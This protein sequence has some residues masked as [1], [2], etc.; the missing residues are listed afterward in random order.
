MK[1]GLAVGGVLLAAPG[2]VSCGGENGD[3]GADDEQRPLRGLGRRLLRRG[4]DVREHLQRDGHGQPARGRGGAQGCGQELKYLGTPEDIPDGAREGLALTL[5]KLTALPDDADQADLL[6]VLDLNQRASGPSR[7]R[8]R[9]TSTTPARTARAPK[10]D[11]TSAPPAP[12]CEG[13]ELT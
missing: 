3:S 8:S 9:T 10:A 5:D 2:L 4:S 12:S 1:L 7:W 13:G 11:P 6:D